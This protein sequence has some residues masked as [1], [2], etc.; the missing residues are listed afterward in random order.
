M[1]KLSVNTLNEAQWDGL[2]LRSEYLALTQCW[3]WG[4]L[5]EQMGWD[6]HRIA[7]SK[8]GSPK[9]DSPIAGMQLLTKTLPARLGGVAYVPRGPLGDWCDPDVAQLLFEG[10]HQTAREAGCLFLKTEPQLP[11]S[12]EARELMRGLGFIESKDTI[13]PV[14]TILL[15]IS[16]DPDSLYKSLRR[17]TRWKINYTEKHGVTVRRGGEEDL[18]VF[19][20]HMLETFK[21]T[22]MAVRAFDRYRAEYLTFAKK[23]RAV[24]LIAEHEGV[25]IASHIAYRFGDGAAYFHGG[26]SA[27]KPKLHPNAMLIWEQILWAKEHGCTSFD[28]WGIPDEVR[29]L[30]ADGEEIPV[31]RTDGL[32]GVYRFKRGFSK[33]V[34]PFV[35]SFDYV[36]APRR[37]AVTRHLFAGDNSK[38]EKISGRIEAW[39]AGV[40]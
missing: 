31:E 35:G 9:E 2:A 26:A 22:G 5:K 17:S 32:W 16:A 8:E 10:A 23:D 4:V 6:I 20:R 38:L 11:D 1:L 12:P 15:D 18:G 36:Y 24:L 29:Q 14:A 27:A 34:F 33:E 28:L 30:L 13:Q 37:Y 7:V 19:Y 21:R 39:R 25:P 40:R 3:D